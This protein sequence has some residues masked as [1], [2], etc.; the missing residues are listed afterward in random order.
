[1]KKLL[2]LITAFLFLSLNSQTPKV[3]SG[4][5]IEYQNFNSVNIGNRNVRIWLPDNYDPRIKHQVLFANDGQMLWD[6]TI[7]WNQQEWKLDEVLG[8]LIKEKKVKP[9]IVVAVDNAGVNRH[10]EYFPQKPFESLTRKTQDSLYTL[11]RQPNQLLFAS[12]VYS[13]QYLKFL[14]E[15]LKPFV[16]RNYT[17]YKNN[18]HTFIMGSSMGGL[19]SMYAATEYPN[20][21]GGAIC[22]STHWPGIFSAENNPVPQA[23]QNYLKE[24]LPK[25]GK[26]KYYFDF[27]TETLDAM[28][29]LH[30]KEV[31]KIMRE[32][33]YT[34]KYWQTLKFSG[35]AHTEEAWAQRLVIPLS[36]MLR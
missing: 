36:M 27:G 19:I 16:E 7:T 11:K 33:K 20:I 6:G 8:K 30:Q 21:F 29:E 9:T 22:M 13:D 10:S 14:V 3:S 26:N 2:I 32:K 4:K 23:F 18:K 15:E 35:A 28:Y 25:Y 17:T 31:D 34:K 5:I 1:M 24:N 12:K